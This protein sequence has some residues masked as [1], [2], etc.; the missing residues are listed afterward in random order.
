MNNTKYNIKTKA[1]TR[2]WGSYTVLIE[3]N[4]YKVKLVEVSP[5]KKLSL[6]KH[7]KRSEHWVVVEGEA[8]IVEDKKAHTLKPNQSAYI[9]KGELH[10]LENKLNKPL[11]II[12]VQCGKYLEEDDIE[13]LEDDYGREHK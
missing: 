8:K 7:H 10:R 3:G 1:V 5:N 12:E 2:P 11:R 4:G 13:R 6:Q 9:A